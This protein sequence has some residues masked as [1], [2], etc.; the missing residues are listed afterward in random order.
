MKN[1]LDFTLYLCLVLFFTS[2]LN[3]D[4]LTPEDN[5]V[6][7]IGD[8]ELLQSSLDRIP[9]TGK[10]TVRFAD[11][12]GNVVPFNIVE[13]EALLPIEKQLV[14]FNYFEQGD[15]VFL[16]HTSQTKRF[17]IFNESFDLTFNFTLSATPYAPDPENG[18]VADVVNIFCVDPDNDLNA[19]QVFYHE[20][21]QRTW[22][23]TWNPT[24]L[25]SL[26]LIDS[27]FTEVYNNDFVM[28]KNVINF[29]YEFGIL[30]FIGVDGR[31]WRYEEIE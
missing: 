19:S 9:F 16:N 13:T 30:S 12:N 10:T 25:D 31:L 7:E 24:P 2:C 22:P 11:E 23:T 8:F 27:T 14:K 5:E 3:D 18:Y 1:I 17:T 4:T 15:T 26:T 6:V 29:N 20:T 21:N 28:P